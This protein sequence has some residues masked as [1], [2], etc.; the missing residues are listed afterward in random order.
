[1]S[2]L[3]YIKERHKQRKE[4]YEKCLAA[5]DNVLQGKRS[6]ISL[7]DSETLL[8]HYRQFLLEGEYF[9][10]HIDRMNWFEWFIYGATARKQSKVLIAKAKDVTHYIKTSK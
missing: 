3:N 8:S 4:L 1:M 9:R 7:F 6:G 10:D 2:Y 5:A